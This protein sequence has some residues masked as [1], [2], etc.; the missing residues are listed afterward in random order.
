M[1]TDQR[2]LAI[3]DRRRQFKPQTGWK[4]TAMSMIGYKADGTKNW[5]GKY[6]GFGNVLRDSYVSGWL[7]KGSD[8]EEVIKSQR[9]AEWG[10]Q[11]G[12]AKF[13]TNFIGGGALGGG[14]KGLF[15]KAGTMGKGVGGGATKAGAFI[16]QLGGGSVKAGDSMFANKS[17]DVV[18]NKSAIDKITDGVIDEDKQKIKDNI[19][20]ND[21]LPSEDDYTVGAESATTNSSKENKVASGIANKTSMIPV[22]GEAAGLYAQNLQ[23]ADKL[24]EKRNSMFKRKLKRAE[25]QYQ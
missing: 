19:F 24:E 4:K 8:A 3:Q 14:G 10:K 25:Y 2:E 22:I 1:F 21:T 5:Y 20:N 13:A 18:A 15:S 6:F 23:I 9:G 7:G 12:I 17:T 16:S 11:I